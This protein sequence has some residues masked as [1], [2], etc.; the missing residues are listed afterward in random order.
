MGGREKSK[1]DKEMPLGQ[2]A[3]VRPF[4]MFGTK[5]KKKGFNSYESKQCKQC[6]RMDNERW[7]ASNRE[8]TNKNT[9]RNNTVLKPTSKKKTYMAFW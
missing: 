4:T 7:M 2:V 3:C 5:K 8:L 1:G 6:K 9:K